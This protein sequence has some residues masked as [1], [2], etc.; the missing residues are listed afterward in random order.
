[1]TACP[2]CRGTG[3]AYMSRQRLTLAV[4]RRVDGRLATSLTWI[5]ACQACRG[6]GKLVDVLLR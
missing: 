3:R 4:G 2:A 6:S 5:P 1:M